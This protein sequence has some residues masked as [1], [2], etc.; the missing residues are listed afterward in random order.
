MYQ[1]RSG[2]VHG[3]SLTQID[4]DIAFGWDPPWWQERALHEALWRVSRVALRN[5][6]ADPAT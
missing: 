5:W 1:L 4:E 6:L 3:S 2:I